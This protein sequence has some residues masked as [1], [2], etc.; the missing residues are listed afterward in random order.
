MAKVN[1]VFPMAPM[2]RR[3][4]LT[5]AAALTVLLVGFCI[6]LYAALGKFEHAPRGA[7]MLQAL[8]PL[9][10]IAIFVASF[11]GERSRV[12]QF[13]IEENVLVLRKKR[14]PLLGLTSAERDREVLKGAR[15]RWGNSGVGAIRGSFRSKRLGDFEAFLTDPENAVVLK[16]PGRVVAVSP[17]DPDFL[18]YSARAASGLT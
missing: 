10:P 6:N 8:V 16:W 9:L 18:I 3:V 7:R 5:M 14:F 15:R 12:S 2:G 4:I 11:L 17:A 13:R 1:Q